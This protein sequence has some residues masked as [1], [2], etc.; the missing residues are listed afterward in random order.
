MLNTNFFIVESPEHLK[1]LLSADLKQ[2]PVINLWAPWAEATD[3]EEC[4]K[5]NQVVQEL[6]EKYPTALFLQVIK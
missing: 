1:E 2:I 6:A 3:S 4:H 5:M